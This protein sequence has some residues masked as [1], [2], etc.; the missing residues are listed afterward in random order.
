MSIK[1]SQF[2][3][4]KANNM[5][6]TAPTPGITISPYRKRLYRKQKPPAK[7]DKTNKPPADMTEIP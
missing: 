7:S 2:Y 6:K 3:N 5:P 1:N 4:I